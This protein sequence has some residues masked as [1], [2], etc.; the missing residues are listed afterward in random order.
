[1][2]ETTVDIQIEDISRVK[3]KLI[4]DVSWDEVK[5]ELDA[6]YREVGKKA[7]VRGFRQGKVPRKILES[8]YKNY[9]EGEAVTNIVNKYYWNAIE[10]K[11]IQAISQPHIEQNGII[12]EKNFVFT[13][14]VEVEPEIDPQG[15]VGLELVKEIQDVTDEDVEKKLQEMRSMFS[16][17]E[18]VES[19]REIQEGDFTLIDFEGKI[20]DKVIPGMK[21]D[22]YLLE[23]GSR[24]FVPGFEKQLV[25]MKKGEAK[26]FQ[27]EFPSDYHDKELAGKTVT[28]SVVV[29]GIKEKKLPDLDE[30]FVRNFQSYETLDEMKSD[31]RSRLEKEFAARTEMRLRDQIIDR[32]IALNEFEVPPTFVERQISYMVADTQRRMAIRGASRERRAEIGERLREMYRDEAQKIVKTSLLLKNIARKESISVEESEVEERIRRLAEEQGHTFD[33]MKASLEKAGMME[34][35]RNDILQDKVFAFIEHRAKVT[36]VPKG[37]TYGG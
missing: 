17:L 16:T 2:A 13:A 3:K 23:I 21:S 24:I 6:V 9:A 10:E 31:I 22:N 30:Q 20:E 35:L 26:D 1:M 29:K 34:S 37:E 32:L 12:Y 8:L 27:I 14:T 7:R 5:K 19:D 25:G 36:T 28:F 11:N 33:E 4:F 15:Y 18:E